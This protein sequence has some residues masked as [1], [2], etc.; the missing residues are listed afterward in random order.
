MKTDSQASDDS[1]IV[2]MYVSA[3]VDLLGLSSSLMKL[4]GLPISGAGTP[5][6]GGLVKDSIGEIIKFRQLVKLIFDRQVPNEETLPE[7]AT[8][9][10]HDRL[11][12]ITSQSHGTA[13]RWFSDCCLISVPSA[14]GH[15]ER[16]MNGI[17]RLFVSLS[18]MSVFLLADGQPMRGGVEVGYGGDV[19]D[20]EVIASGLAKA[21]EL[22][23]RVANYPRVAV[24]PHLQEVLQHPLEARGPARFSQIT[25]SLRMKALAMLKPMENGEGLSFID[26]LGPSMMEF[27]RG[28][29]TGSAFLDAAIRR[30]RQ[31]VKDGSMDEGKR[32]KYEWL[33][34]YMADSGVW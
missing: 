28:N 15:P 17:Y 10:A 34:S 3:F 29:A 31:A 22:E 24:G 27:F 20:G 9:S 30:V 5:E 2:R 19:G 4:E 21:Y 16:M 6:S 12:F 1:I 33:Q 26:F 13:F 18:A 23:S 11:E 7:L 14:E 8:L 32:S 25:R